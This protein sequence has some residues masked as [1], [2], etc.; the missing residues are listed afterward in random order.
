MELIWL[1]MSMITMRTAKTMESFQSTIRSSSCRPWS[2]PTLSIR[3]PTTHKAKSKRP[4]ASMVSTASMAMATTS[5]R[6]PSRTTTR[7][8]LLSLLTGAKLTIEM[9]SCLAWMRCKTISTTTRLEALSSYQTQV[10][11]I[12]SPQFWS[13]KDWDR[14]RQFINWILTWTSWAISQHWHWLPTRYCIWLWVGSKI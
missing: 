7:S 5:I 4:H 14:Q 1:P 13:A 3:I 6:S 2:Y 9:D 8:A 12:M 10:K 11:Q